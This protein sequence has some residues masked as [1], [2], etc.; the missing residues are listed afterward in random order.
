MDETDTPARGDLL[1]GGLHTLFLKKGEECVHHGGAAPGAT[2][3]TAVDGV[4]FTGNVGGW[5][6]IGH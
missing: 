6:R 1:D 3:A 2:G 5:D 4:G